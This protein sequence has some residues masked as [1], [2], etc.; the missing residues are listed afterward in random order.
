MKTE[1][2]DRLDGLLRLRKGQ[3]GVYEK[4]D[5]ILWEDAAVAVCEAV[6]SE[7]EACAKLIDLLASDLECAKGAMCFADKIRARGKD[8]AQ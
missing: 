4:G 6:A 8:V 3:L 2:S 5:L 7:R 1:D